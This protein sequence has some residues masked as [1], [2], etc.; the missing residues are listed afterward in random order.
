MAKYKVGD[1]V[2]VRSDL[3]TNGESYKMNDYKSGFGKYCTVVH[4]KE[5]F[6]KVVTITEVREQDCYRIKEDSEK[7]KWTDEM[8]IGLAEEE[9]RTYKIGDRVIASD[10]CGY[11]KEMPGTI[12]ELW[13]DMNHPTPYGV[14]FDSE[15]KTRVTLWSEVH[16]LIEEDPT[17]KPTPTTANVNVTINLYENACWYCRKGGLVDLYLAGQLGI[18]PSCGRVCNNTTPTT[19]KNNI[20][21]EFKPAKKNKPLTTEELRAL[22]DGAKVFTVWCNMGRGVETWDEPF[23]TWRTKDKGN[24]KWAKGHVDINSNTKW[25]KAYLEEPERPF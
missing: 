20:V 1:K 25:F 18:C 5:F 9:K 17:P 3:K 2:L 7:W 15:E 19:P 22:P 12:T 21:I 8:F 16:S 14:K 24:L 13:P 4:M 11:Y 10:N 6:G 23:T